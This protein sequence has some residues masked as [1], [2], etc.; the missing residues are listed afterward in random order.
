M[1]GSKL[2]PFDVAS[3]EHLL[4]FGHVLLNPP[5]IHSVNKEKQPDKPVTFNDDANEEDKKSDQDF[6]LEIDVPIKLKDPL[7]YAFVRSRLKAN[8]YIVE[9]AD[10]QLVGDLLKP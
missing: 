7:F 3:G 8:S 5:Y 1:I 10:E 9:A 2:G 6:L 4:A